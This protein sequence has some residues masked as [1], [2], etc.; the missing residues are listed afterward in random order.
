[1]RLPSA[2]HPLWDTLF[3]LSIFAVFISSLFFHAHSFD[4]SELRIIGECSAFTSIAAAAL[5][6]LRKRGKRSK[7]QP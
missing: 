3:V 2:Q 7:S 5:V 6:Y 4:E 1:M